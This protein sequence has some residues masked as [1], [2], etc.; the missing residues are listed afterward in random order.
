MRAIGVDLHKDLIVACFLE[1]D[2][3][4][5]TARFRLTAD[6]LA[7]FRD[8]LRSDDRLA[9]EAGRN[10]WFFLARVADAV[11]EAVVVDPRRFAPIAASKKKTDER[12]ALELAR[13]LRAGYL[14][15]VPIPDARII[16]LGQPFAA[17]ANLVNTDTQ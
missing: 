16:R 12:D 9:V 1:E 15:T 6:G 14:P 8:R 13:A 10:V 17:P 2:G 3:S 4:H 11:G 7:A 5:Q